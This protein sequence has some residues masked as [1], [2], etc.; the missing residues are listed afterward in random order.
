ML[1]ATGAS[2]AA[3]AHFPSSNGAPLGRPALCDSIARLDRLVVR[4]RETFPQN[5]LRFSFPAVVRV[6]EAAAVK[7]VATALCA[8]PR[9]PSGAL[10]CPA[11]LGVAYQLTFSARTRPF[12][13]VRVDPS[14]CQTVVGLGPTRWVARS[15]GFWKILG[16]ALGLANPGNEVFAG[17]GP[18]T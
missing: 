16:R 15:P 12:P 1:A 17:R 11:D 18:S 3:S 7:E 10:F 2:A 13:T 9:L 4:R 8:L 6:D 5:Q 14:G